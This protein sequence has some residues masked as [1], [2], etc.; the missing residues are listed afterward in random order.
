MG[1]GYYICTL[2]TVK[3]KYYR[4]FQTHIGYGCEAS[5]IAQSSLEKLRYK[6]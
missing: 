4:P 5:D 1:L 6:A 2:Y 3:D